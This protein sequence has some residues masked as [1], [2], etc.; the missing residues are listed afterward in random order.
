MF[1]RCLDAYIFLIISN[2]FLD[3]VSGLMLLLDSFHQ[4]PLK[5][6]D[7]MIKNRVHYCFSF[8]LGYAQHVTEIYIRF[9][10]RDMF[11]ISF[12]KLDI[13]YCDMYKLSKT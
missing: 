6:T 12:F 2:V 3:F 13:Q 5:F 1:N 9:V 10:I 8:R 7:C 11:T 4:R